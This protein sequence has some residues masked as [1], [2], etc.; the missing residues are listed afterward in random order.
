MKPVCSEHECYNLTP[1]TVGVVALIE[2]GITTTCSEPV[3][4]LE[5][6]LILALL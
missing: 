2:V 1:E 6:L 5:L 3:Q 4:I